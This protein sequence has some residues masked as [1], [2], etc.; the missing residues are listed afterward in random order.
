M[1]ASCAFP[2]G[3]YEINNGKLE[4]YRLV[5]GFYQPLAANERGH[6]PLRHWA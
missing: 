1:S 2:H 6:Y 3:I 4:V 5:D